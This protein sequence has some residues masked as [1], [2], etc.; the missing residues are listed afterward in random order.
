MVYIAYAHV[1]AQGKVYFRGKKK[2]KK[3]SENLQ[4]LLHLSDLN[5]FKQFPMKDVSMW[6][7]AVN[8]SFFA[9]DLQLSFCKRLRL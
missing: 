3:R 7:K 9:G 4:Y 2:E 1:P 6:P 8:S 5:T